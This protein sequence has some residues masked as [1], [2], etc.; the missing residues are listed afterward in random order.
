MPTLV[1][2]RGTTF[3]A[4]AKVSSGLDP[5]GAAFAITCHCELCDFDRQAGAIGA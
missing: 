2:G 4:V 3:D 1:R 5:F